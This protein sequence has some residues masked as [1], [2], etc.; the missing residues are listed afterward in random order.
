MDLKTTAKLWHFE[1]S[2]QMYDY[3]RQLMYYTMAAKWYIENELND[4][5]SEWKFLYYIIG[6]D[7]T[8][9]NE[10]RVFTLH[11]WQVLARYND[12]CHALQDIAW[13]QINNKWDHSREYYEGDGSENLNL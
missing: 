13:H 12:I 5:P 9:T 1:E 7:T 8:G 3:C 11:E 4:N 6:I 10:I 2:I